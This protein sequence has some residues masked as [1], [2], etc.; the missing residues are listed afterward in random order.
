[1]QKRLHE[2][3]S[4]ILLIT[5]IGKHKYKYINDLKGNPE[6]ETH[7]HDDPVELHFDPFQ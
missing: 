1:M 3:G 6:G 2:S 4:S 5:I 7:T